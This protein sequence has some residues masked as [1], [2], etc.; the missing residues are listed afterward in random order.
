[1]SGPR[2]VFLDQPLRCDM[3]RDELD[4]AALPFDPKMQHRL[5]ALDISDTQSAELLA[6]HA[7]IEEGR[8][9]GA[10]A[11]ALDGIFWR[12]IEQLARLLAFLIETPSTYEERARNAPPCKICFQDP[13]ESPDFQVTVMALGISNKY[14]RG[15][16]YSSPFQSFSHKGR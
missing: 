5:T 10:I 16:I 4:L 12:R 7:V 6:A 8:E 3:H 1:M 14:P 13:L 2:Q 9:D 11:D 15:C